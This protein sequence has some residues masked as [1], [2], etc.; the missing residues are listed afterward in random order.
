MGEEIDE[1]GSFW[2]FEEID[3]KFKEEQQAMAVPPFLSPL[4]PGY[5]FYCNFEGNLLD[6][7]G[8]KD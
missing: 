6:I 1:E 3:V 4:V 2:G 7:H 8:E 5:V